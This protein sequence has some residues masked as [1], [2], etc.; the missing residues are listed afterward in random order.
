MVSR[1]VAALVVVLAVVAGGCTDD[2]EPAMTKAEYLDQGNEIC[3]DASDALDDAA[4]EAGLAQADAAGQVSFIQTEV[5]PSVRRQIA[6]LRELGFPPGDEEE[7]DDLYDD[8]EDT[9]IVLA[10]DPASLLRIEGESP[11]AAINMRL[12][13][14]GLEDC[15]EA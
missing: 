12:A 8:A 3:A 11:F 5:V 2:A 14:Y 6:D 13:D 9:L 10:R 7:L 1:A 4:E 15:S